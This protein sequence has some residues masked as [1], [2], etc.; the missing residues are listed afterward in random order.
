M[1]AK[2]IADFQPNQTIVTFAVIRSV[3]SRT[4]RSGEEFLALQLQDRTGTIEAKIWEV[5]EPMR[6]L[7]AGDY[8]KVK[9]RVEDYRGTLQL[10]VEKIRKASEADRARGF[11]ESDL[12][13]ST[14]YDID[15]MWGRLHT[16]V[17]GEVA[18]PFVLQLL[19]NVL[20]RTGERFKYYPAAQEIHHGYRGG[21]LEHVLSVTESCAYVA[22]RYPDV[23]K[24][25]LI[26]GG[27]LHD[28]GKLQELTA[29]PAVEY[30]M[31]GRLIGHII[32]G[33]D[34]VRAEAARIPNFPERTLLLIEHLIVSHHGDYDL[35]SPKRPKILE[36]LI[37]HY[38]DD[39]D[40]KVNH[41]QTAIHAH[42]GP[43]PFTGYDRILGRVLC[44]EKR[45]SPLP[46]APDLEP[47]EEDVSDSG[48]GKLFGAS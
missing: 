17:E 37:L 24:D 47:Q 48:P 21:F 45:L 29:A 5:E 36:A 16:L 30:T 23:D 9:G 10:G 7:R 44:K 34:L 28:I 12:V 41:F 14:P 33:R 22:G 3:W 11:R 8:V 38:L 18:D 40:A 13:I 6:Q 1:T 43:G 20:E 4:K 2:F 19:K 25:L 31:E 46:P 27:I 32:L 15:A 35:G 42:R 39:M 26:A